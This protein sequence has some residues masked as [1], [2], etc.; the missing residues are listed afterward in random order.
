MWCVCV[1]V[2]AVHVVTIKGQ[3]KRMAARV[4]LRP[5]R[6]THTRRRQNTVCVAFE[7]DGAHRNTQ[8]HTQPRTIYIYLSGGDEDE[9]WG[10]G[11]T[12]TH[13]SPN[14]HTSIYI[15]IQS[16]LR[17]FV[18][19][20]ANTPQGLV[21]RKERQRDFHLICIQI[22]FTSGNSHVY[23]DLAHLTGL[24]HMRV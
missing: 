24:A 5:R 1:C 22:V 9:V 14:T 19:V 23:K 7:P 11:R 8:T 15:H 3:F 6:V 4:V 17:A 21:E 18:C 12:H 20:S 13:I 2:Y 16:D 10:V